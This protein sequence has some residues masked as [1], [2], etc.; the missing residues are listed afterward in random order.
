LPVDT[1]SEYAKDLIVNQTHHDKMKVALDYQ[2]D[3]SKGTV[4]AF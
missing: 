2:Y 3:K 1:A 4:K